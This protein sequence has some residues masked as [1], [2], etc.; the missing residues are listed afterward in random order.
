MRDARSPTHCA[1]RALRIGRTYRVQLQADAP[2]R[3]SPD[4]LGRVFVRSAASGETI[5]LKAR[6]ATR[7]VVG[8]EQPERFNGFV[9]AK[10]LGAGKPGVSSGDAIRAVEEVAARVLPAGYRIAWTGPAFQE[11]RADSASVFAFGFAIVMVDS[12]G[13]VTRLA[14]RVTWNCSTRSARKTTPNW[15]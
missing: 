13:R 9:A 2:Y 10:V 15:R 5:A 1:L 11:M 12:R 3:A 14:I 4:D 7:S 6:I 8:P